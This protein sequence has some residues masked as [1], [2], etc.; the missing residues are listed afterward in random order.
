V[1]LGLKF[2]CTVHDLIAGFVFRCAKLLGIS[3]FLC[4]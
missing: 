4:S 1:I 3:M 2:M